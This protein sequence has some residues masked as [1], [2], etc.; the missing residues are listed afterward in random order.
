MEHGTSLVCRM[1]CGR[2]SGRYMPVPVLRACAICGTSFERRRYRSGKLNTRKTCGKVCAYRLS[3]ASYRAALAPVVPRRRCTVCGSLFALW[4]VK[5]GHTWT[6]AKTCGRGCQNIARSSAMEQAH[7][8][9]ALDPER[10]Q[11]WIGRDYS[12]MGR[13]RAAL[14][15]ISRKDWNREREKLKKRKSKTAGPSW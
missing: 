5:A 11:Q 7:E 1:A 10:Y 9:A 6:R 13:A 8:V 15:G 14:G 3:G 12:A 4:R 2:G